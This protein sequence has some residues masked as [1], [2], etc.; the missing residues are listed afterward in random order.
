MK[1][2]IN[3]KISYNT[4]VT[5]SFVFAALLF[6]VLNNF[7]LKQKLGFLASPTAAG[8]SL[9]FNPSNFSSYVRLVFY[10]FGS[11]DFALLI[12]NCIFILLLGTEIEG[13]YGS[14]VIGIMM[15]VSSLFSGVL[16]ACFCNASLE[17]SVSV[18]FMLF[19]LNSFASFS[20]KNI[21]LSQAAL[22]ILLLINGFLQSANGIAGVIINVAGGLCGGL[23]AFLVSPKAK[24]AR[25]ENPSRSGLK[26]R[27]EQIAE[28]D[29]QSP[30]FQN[31]YYGS[32]SSKQ[33]YND[34]ETTVIGTLKF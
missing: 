24:A 18:I 29:S 27:A 10:S 17:G 34:N 12:T 33:S 32:D 25:K 5:L 30:R 14:V 8:G 7:V 22:F 26:S 3:I 31:K 21:P 28:I 4:P 15:T 20:K 2:K 23:F 6:F 1:K 19:F 9:P 16:N 13:L 11:R